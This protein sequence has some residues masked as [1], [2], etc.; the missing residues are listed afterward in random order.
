MSKHS[1]LAHAVDTVE[2]ALEPGWE[3]L[4]RKDPEHG[5][6]ANITNPLDAT[7]KVKYHP[8][9]DEDAA[10]ALT[11]SLTAFLNGVEK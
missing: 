3:W 6:F 9:Y 10:T 7:R 11:L 1:R 8:A 2:A 5:Y 4:L